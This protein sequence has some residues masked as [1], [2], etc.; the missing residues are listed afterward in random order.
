MTPLSTLLPFSAMILP[1]ARL[2]S[3]PPAIVPLSMN[4]VATLPET[5]TNPVLELATV[6]PEII[7]SPLSA[8]MVLELANGAVIS[9]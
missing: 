4:S 9:T 8:S 7:I 1:P 6:P 3:L 5:R 2:C